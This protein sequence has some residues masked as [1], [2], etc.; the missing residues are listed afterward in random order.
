MTL[1]SLVKFCKTQ[2]QILQKHRNQRYL[3]KSLSHMN[4]DLLRDIGI[5][6][7]RVNKCDPRCW[8]E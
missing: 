5:N 1:V 8:F 7:Q 4:N 6:P 2:W 3:I